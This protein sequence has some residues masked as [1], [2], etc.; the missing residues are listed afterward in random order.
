[1]RRILDWLDG[2][3][4]GWPNL[5][6]AE[7]TRRLDRRRALYVWGLLAV[8]LALVFLLYRCWS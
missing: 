5:T 1:M 4:L 6:L 8:G 3:D 2:A 7:F